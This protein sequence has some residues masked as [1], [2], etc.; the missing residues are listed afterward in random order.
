ML[1]IIILG[2]LGL[3]AVILVFQGIGYVIG[4]LIGP[5]IAAAQE[6][7]KKGSADG[8]DPH[9]VAA[10]YGAHA[11]A[12]TTVGVTA[13]LWYIW[14][15][16]WIIYAGGAVI[17]VTLLA[18]LAAQKAFESASADGRDPHQAALR[19]GVGVIAWASSA[20]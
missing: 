11:L 17:A 15:H 7:F 14:G 6:G 12:W 5:T 8:R 20:P 16:G 9:L 13:L 10:K 1:E 19:Y 3:I 4:I 18:L 2:V